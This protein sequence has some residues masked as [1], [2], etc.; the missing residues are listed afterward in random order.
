MSQHSSATGTLRHGPDFRPATVHHATRD[1]S[2]RVWEVLDHWQHPAP[3]PVRVTLPGV[4]ECWKLRVRGPLPGEAGRSGEFV[5]T[6]RT[7]GNRPGWELVPQPV[8]SRPLPSWLSL[9]RWPCS[10]GGVRDGTTARDGSGNARKSRPSVSSGE[11]GKSL[12]RS[13]GSLARL[14]R[15]RSRAC[16][17]G[18]RGRSGATQRRGGTGGPDHA[19]SRHSPVWTFL[20]HPAGSVSSAPSHA[21]AASTAAVKDLGPVPA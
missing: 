4:V 21:I 17:R 12:C 9:G 5:M 7:Y 10:R 6:V 18:R 13:P 15:Q 19:G 8:A 20:F 1:L 3:A 14:S 11:P 2:W 16:W